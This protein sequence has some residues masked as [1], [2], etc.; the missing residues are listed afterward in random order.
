MTLHVCP[1]LPL[2][3][4]K[5]SSC[6]PP[7]VV[8]DVWSLAPFMPNLMIQA[9]VFAFFVS[10]CC[11][12]VRVLTVIVFVL[13]AE[14]SKSRMECSSGGDEVLGLGSAIIPPETTVGHKNDLMVVFLSFFFLS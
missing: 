12:C 5:T 4:D 2:L 10:R 7:P 6:P 9:F 14:C 8:R 1:L 3:S 11:V 13:I